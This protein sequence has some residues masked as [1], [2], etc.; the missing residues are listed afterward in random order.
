MAKLYRSTWFPLL[1]AC[2]YRGVKNLCNLLCV[3]ALVWLVS[4]SSY[5]FKS[6]SICF[7]RTKY[8][9]NCENVDYLH[10]IFWPAWLFNLRYIELCEMSHPPVLMD[11]TLNLGDFY[12]ALHRTVWGMQHASSDGQNGKAA[13]FFISHYI[14]LSEVGHPLVLM[15]KTHKQ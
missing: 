13:W 1:S 7:Q 9:I 4:I 15:D 2:R 3:Y 11:E 12:F 5:V 6:P 8:G 14:K 10:S